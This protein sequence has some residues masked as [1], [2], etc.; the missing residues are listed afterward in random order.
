M[1]RVNFNSSC[2]S[3]GVVRIPE[4][5]RTASA[6]YLRP[7]LQSTQVFDPVT[8]EGCKDGLDVDGNPCYP[9]STKSN[10]G[11]WALVALAVV[12]AIVFSKS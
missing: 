7:T 10:T 6:S 2:G 8:V 9:E 4:I 12:G 5:S 1:M 3:C 11:L